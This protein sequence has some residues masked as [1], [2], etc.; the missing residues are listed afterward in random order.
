MNLRLTVYLLYFT[1][2]IGVFG[3]DGTQQKIDSLNQ[4]I[5]SQT[6]ADTTKAA[7]YG[8]L[9]ATYA[10]FKMDTVEA[11]CLKG[12]HFI[13][14]AKTRAS[15]RTLP[16]IL[17]IESVLYTN[18]GY[19]YYHI[20][21]LQKAIDLWHKSLELKELLEDKKGMSHVLNNI[22][23]LEIDLGAHDR[24]ESTFNSVLS[25]QQE[26]GDSI[27]ISRTYVNLGYLKRLEGN[28]SLALQ[29]YRRALELKQAT[30]DQ[31][32]IANCYN[33]IGFIYKK[34]EEYEQA[35]EYY[36]K[37]KSIY[38]ITNNNY[39]YLA[40]LNNLA[41]CYYEM[42]RLNEAKRLALNGYKIA[43]S[44][45]MVKD[46]QH[47]SETLYKI[48]KKQGDYQK[49]LKYYEDY[50]TIND[51]LTDEAHYKSLIDKELQYEFE[52]KEK[53]RQLEQQKAL[54]LQRIEHQHQLQ[55][56]QEKSFRLWITIIII[57][58]ALIVVGL[59][60]YYI[61]RQ[62]IRVK[63]QRETIEEQAAKLE[64]VALRSQMNPHF[65]FNCLNAIKSYIIQNDPKKAASYLNKFARLVRKVLENS[66]K[67]LIDLSEEI[68]VLED[69]VTLE[70]LRFPQPFKFDIKHDVSLE[71][72]QV[73]P[74][75]LQP[76][77]E[78][79]IW[80]GLL[81]SDQAG[82]IEINITAT[83]SGYEISIRDN[84]IGREASKKLNTNLAH[85]SSMGMEIT[86]QRLQQMFALT[87]V[88]TD[89]NIVDLVD[90]KGP[91]GTEVKITLHY[92]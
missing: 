15:Q 57:L 36:L 3:Q 14:I 30:G 65:L 25:I 42:N 32:G 84:G 67:D 47:L 60:L 62:L 73:P 8:T 37:A 44:Q 53:I 85:K 63:R 83:E 39:G 80:H 29:Y 23:N 59:L 24:A 72:I 13:S 75:I 82:K 76:Y 78:N 12:L 50:V 2:T 22:G 21:E 68:A 7:A 91:K 11:I 43:Q 4:I 69:Y 35:V 54:E 79:S 33:N 51:S 86:E 77:V 58:M 40:V 10:S 41:S 27:G 18:Q 70:K 48:L 1:T 74:L 89:V 5:Q 81:K 87:A 66:N 46:I 52:Q 64:L 49:A 61:R 71:E 9:S 20:G 6:H 45:Q 56:E 90:E 92:A 55:L 19:A 26:L 28:D 38:E 34:S 31:S 17:E 16:R 88:K